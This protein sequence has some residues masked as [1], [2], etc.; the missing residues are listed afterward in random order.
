MSETSWKGELMCEVKRR[1]FL[2]LSATI[3]GGGLIAGKTGHSFEN[4]IQGAPGSVHHHIHLVSVM[5]ET[6]HRFLAALS[7]EQKAKATFKFN[8]DERMD[9][10]FIPKERK[11]LT[12]GEMSPD[13]KHLASALLA[14]GLSQ[15]GYIKAVTIMSLEDVLK[16]L[17][18]DSGERRNPEKYHF[19]VFGTPSD[20][21]IWGWRVEGHHLSQNYTIANGQVVDGPSFFG[22][23]P[24]E[25]RQGPRKGLRT[26]A[27]EDDLGFEVI[28]ALDEPQQKIAIVDP[29][30]YGD[31]LTAASRK[32]ALEGQPSGIPATKMNQ[33][34]FEVLRALVELYA[35]NVPN[36]LAERRMAQLNKA[37]HNVY[38]AWAGG[39]KL[40][41]LHYYRVQTPSFLI[42]FDDTQDNA[43]H[44]HSVWRDFDG[45]FGGDMLRAHYETSHRTEK[46][47]LSSALKGWPRP[48]FE[49]PLTFVKE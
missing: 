7:P 12:L 40:G 24:A 39:I 26:L 23:N 18:N 22:S 9:W 3:L 4:D 19:T 17:E 28:H 25:V 37:G 13:Q 47:K 38:F 1:S 20:T 46:G 5:T 29:K 49:R 6:A 45:D 44:I 33:G 27:S 2:G 41:D 36:E 21:G 30:A 32:A 48:D 15:T 16:A 8:D 31:I 11:G 34:Q 42:E 14:A 43:N 10:H 35:R